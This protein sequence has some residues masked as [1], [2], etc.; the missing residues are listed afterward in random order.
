M[1]TNDAASPP[2]GLMEPPPTATGLM[3]PPPTAT[4]LMEPP[5]TATGLMEPPPTATGLME[6]PP[7]ATGLMEPP[8]TATGL[9]EPPPTATG[10]M[11]PPPTATGLMQPPTIANMKEPSSFTG[12]EGSEDDES[13]D[14]ENND[15]DESEGGGCGDVVDKEVVMAEEG[16]G[17]LSLHNRA[18]QPHRDQMAQVEGGAVHTSYLHGDGETLRT[19]VK[20]SVAKKH[21]QQVR[22]TQPKR[23]SRSVCTRSIKAKR[24]AMRDALDSHGWW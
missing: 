9:M 8:P 23:D 3:E 20:K 10:L 12:H 19:L 21:K 24:G 22:R 7:T 14:G 17:D 2:A 16:L 15:D 4:G 5:P 18:Y 6:P 1:S 13:E 11:E